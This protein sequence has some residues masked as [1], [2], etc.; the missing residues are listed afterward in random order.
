MEAEID[1]MFLPY[2]G[3]IKRT[4]VDVLVEE[5]IGDSILRGELVK[6]KPIYLNLA[7]EFDFEPY[8]EF[9]YDQ[10]KYTTTFTRNLKT[11]FKQTHIIVFK[12]L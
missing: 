8:S 1:L 12:R 11:A 2:D 6:M 9:S 4:L 10:R 5:L 3:E 7:N